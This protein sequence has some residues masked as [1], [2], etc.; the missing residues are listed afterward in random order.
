MLLA[1]SKFEH[2]LGISFQHSPSLW[3]FAGGQ[4]TMPGIFCFWANVLT[5]GTKAGTPAGSGV[6]ISYALAQLKCL[7]HGND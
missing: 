2:S 3:L 4:P 7:T 1:F 6:Y 5:L